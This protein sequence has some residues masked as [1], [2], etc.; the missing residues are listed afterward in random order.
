MAS[1]VP[2]LQMSY[3]QNKVIKPRTIKDIRTSLKGS[4]TGFNSEHILR[5]ADKELES[6]KGPKEFDP[7][8]NAYKALTIFEFEKGLLMLSVIP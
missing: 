7:D 8:T 5:L 3:A 6:V 1:K 2:E 4:G